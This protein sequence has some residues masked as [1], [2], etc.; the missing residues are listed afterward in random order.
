MKFSK[1]DH[2]KFVQ[3][4]LEMLVIPKLD[5][6][7]INKISEAIFFLLRYVTARYRCSRLSPTKP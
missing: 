1:E 7:A 3:L 4:L 5:P 2:V 6:D